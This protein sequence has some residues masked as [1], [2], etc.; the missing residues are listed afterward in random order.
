MNRN[1]KKIWVF[2]VPV[3][4]KW[5]IKDTEDLLG[6]MVSENNGQHTIRLNP[7][8]D[9]HT[10]ELTLFHEMIHAALRISGTSYLLPMNMEEAIVRS[11]ENGIGKYFKFD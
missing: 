7:N 6:E 4:I 10:A 1:I 9:D 11:I 2:G 5:D 8:M 3:A